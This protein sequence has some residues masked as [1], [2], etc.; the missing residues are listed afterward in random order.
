MPTAAQASNAAPEDTMTANT[1][2]TLA[3]STTA[4]RVGLFAAAA[5]G[6][7]WIVS[8]AVEVAGGGISP[9]SMVL[10]IAGCLLLAVGVPSLHRAQA[11]RAGALSLTG[12]AMISV[13]TALEALTDT[14]GW[15][16]DNVEDIQAETGPLIPVFGVLLVLGGIAFGIAILRAGALPRWTGVLLI[17]APPLLPVVNATGLPEVLTSVAKSLIGLAILGAAMAVL[18]SARQQR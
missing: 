15:G 11:H 16:A 8:E 14:I 18:S 10:L 3:P 5:G 17:A 4:A 7:L 2:E 13:A 6:A 12:A 1:G 9:P